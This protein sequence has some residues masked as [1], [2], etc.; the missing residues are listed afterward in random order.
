MNG[1]AFQDKDEIWWLETIGG[2]HWIA[3][4]VPDDVYVVMPNQFGMDEF[5]LDDA[6]GEQKEFMCSSDLK[7]FVE[8]NN[9]N[10][11]QDGGFIPR[12]IFGSIPVSAP[13]PPSIPTIIV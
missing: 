4:K 12:D 8:K 10:L 3:R 2:H 11:S 6:Y 5:D 1:I 9:L 13:M 7:E